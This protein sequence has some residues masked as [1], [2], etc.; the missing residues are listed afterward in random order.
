[1]AT[2]LELKLTDKYEGEIPS[3]QDSYL[4]VG[5]YL[6]LCDKDLD[7]E[8]EGTSKGKSPRTFIKF[9]VHQFEVLRTISLEEHQLEAIFEL[10]LEWNGM[11]VFKKKEKAQNCLL[12]FP[13]P[14]NNPRKLLRG[15]SLL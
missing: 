7:L 1:M 11:V 2:I 12:Y 14:I 6:Y 9:L 10:L 8:Q 4:L 13:D 15:K 3:L 5:Q